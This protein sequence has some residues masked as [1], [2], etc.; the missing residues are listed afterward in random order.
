LV[1]RTYK[2]GKEMKITSIIHNLTGVACVGWD[3][4]SYESYSATAESRRSHP[5]LTSITTTNT[6]RNLCIGIG[7]A[8]FAMTATAVSRLQGVFKTLSLVSVVSDGVLKGW[9]LTSSKPRVR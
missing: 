1:V 5:L 3:A 2:Y 9:R 7:S 6:P 4:R 8:V